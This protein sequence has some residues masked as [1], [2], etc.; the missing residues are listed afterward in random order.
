MKSVKSKI[1]KNLKYRFDLRGWDGED[2]G[3]VSVWI[4]FRDR[5]H[6][7]PLINGRPMIL[8][9]CQVVDEIS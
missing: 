8:L 4:Q 6:F 2:R 5:T 7:M 9:M 1:C 3:A